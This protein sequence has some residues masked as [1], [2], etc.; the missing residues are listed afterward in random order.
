DL[1]NIEVIPAK[2]SRGVDFSIIQNYLDAVKFLKDN[3]IHFD[4]LIN[5]TGQDYPTQP[6]SE[7]QKFLA[8]TTY[9]GFLEYFEVF[10]K[11]SHW[12][13]RE[14]YT[15]YYYKYNQLLS[16]LPEGQKEILNYL[17]VINYIQPFFRLN[18]SYGVTVGLRSSTPFNEKF[19]CYGGSFFCTLS[20]KCVEYLYEFS[21]S[22]T[23]VVN[24]YKGVCVSVES[25]IQTVLVNSQLFNLCNNPKRYFDFYKTRN[26]HP[27]ILT[28]N[29]YPLIVQSNTHFARKFDLSRDS[30]ILDLLDTRILELA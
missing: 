24:Y 22:N 18:F 12:S 14:G 27:R 21:I 25:Y 23:D 26:G 30:K 9:D 10:S 15:R 3:N 29:D 8:E 17:K 1:S 20:R 16:H 2:G 6:L 19:I 28:T 11:E 4:W 13:I 5:I 7:T